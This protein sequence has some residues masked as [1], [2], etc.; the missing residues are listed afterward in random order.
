MADAYG[1]R[2]T[3]IVLLDAATGLAAA[4]GSMELAARLNG[5]AEAG[6][7][8]IGFRREPVDQ[9]FV[10]PW[11]ERA[12]DALGGQ[13]FDAALA[14]GRAMPFDE[15]FDQARRYVET[16]EAATLQIV[17]AALKD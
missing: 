11:V 2:R 12:R 15:A 10:S 5:A 9:A 6:S 8:E 4:C 13:A 3:M 1:S 17:S 7:A 14:A 16:G